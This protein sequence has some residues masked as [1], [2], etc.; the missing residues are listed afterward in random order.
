MKKRFLGTRL[1]VIVENGSAFTEF[2]LD[3]KRWK[4]GEENWM[5]EEEEER[6]DVWSRRLEE[7]KLF[8][9][10]LYEH[11][12]LSLDFFIRELRKLRN[13]DEHLRMEEWSPSLTFNSYS[14]V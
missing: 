13:V 2:G 8:L 10:I 3:E 14:R 6:L 4:G 5:A 1:T 9:W 7:M 12:S 11:Y